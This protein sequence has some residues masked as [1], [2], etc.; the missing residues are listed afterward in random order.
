M[1][2]TIIIGILV[3]EGKLPGVFWEGCRGG[4]SSQAGQALACG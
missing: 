2:S 4:Q 3:L 1:G